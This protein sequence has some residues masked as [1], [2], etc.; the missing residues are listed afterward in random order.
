MDKIQALVINKLS[1]ETKNLLNKY[2]IIDYFSDQTKNISLENEL[3]I[4]I[5]ELKLSN[6]PKKATL[7][8]ISKLQYKIKFGYYSVENRNMIVNISSLFINNSLNELIKEVFTNNCNNIITILNKVLEYYKEQLSESAVSNDY[9]SLFLKIQNIAEKTDNKNKDFIVS[10]IPNFDI[11]YNS[12]EEFEQVKID[13]YFDENKIIAEA[14]VN[15]YNKIE[16][17]YQSDINEMIDEFFDILEYVE[18]K[19]ISKKL[20]KAKYNESF[21]FNSIYLKEKGIH[22]KKKEVIINLCYSKD[23][24]KKLGEHYRL[25][26]NDYIYIYVNNIVWY[27][28]G[29]NIEEYPKNSIKNIKYFIKNC[30][31]F[32]RQIEHQINIV[33]YHELRHTYEWEERERRIVNIDDKKDERKYFMNPDEVNARLLQ[34]IVKAKKYIVYMKEKGKELTIEKLIEYLKDDMAFYDTRSQNFMRKLYKEI[35][36]LMQGAGARA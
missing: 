8:I 18:P 1:E 20:M 6:N 34:Y 16:K 10:Q 23:D 7:F 25:I 15:L 11:L 30:K 19:N 35:Y 24:N 26:N 3:Q 27:V 9:E 5:E 33:I 21:S 28:A 4:K 17:I 32:R 12:L 13:S 22:T 14:T 2:N 36:L 31:L 29:F